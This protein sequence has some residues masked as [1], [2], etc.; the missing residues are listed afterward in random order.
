MKKITKAVIPAAGLGTR[1]LPI[2]R[3]VP[4]EVLPIVD[5][6]AISY[7]VEEAADSG[8]TDILIITGRG[9]G[10]IEDYFDYSLE[11]ENKLR[12]SGREDQIEGLRSI[13]NRCHIHYIR[14]LETKGLGH[15]ITYAKTFVGDDPF[16]VM[17]GDDIIFSEHKPVC[18]QLIDAYEKYGKAVAGVKEVPLELVMKYCTLKADRIAGNVYNIET[19]IE[20]PTIDQIYTRFSILGRVLLT[21]EIFD[22]LDT[23]PPGSGGEIQLTDAMKL[24]AE[25]KGM[26]AVDFDGTRYDLGSKL[27]FLMANVEQG[28]KNPEFGDKFKEYLK[29]FAATL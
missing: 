5:R 29:A 1:M 20:K 19:M 7:L 10:L 28:V 8:I 2:A 25:T 6:P 18:A 12:M 9:K 15:A 21:S 24:L 16:L 11:Y 23:L 3:T 22:I 27:G 26:I 17:Y 14:Q 4:K 13:A